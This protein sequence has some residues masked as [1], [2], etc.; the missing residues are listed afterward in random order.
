MK[1][2]IEL[3]SRYHHGNI[4]VYALRVGLV[5]ELNRAS[6]EDVG[7]IALLILKGTIW[8]DKQ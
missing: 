5:H 3:C 1:E 8:V 2:V 6:N 4:E 7:S